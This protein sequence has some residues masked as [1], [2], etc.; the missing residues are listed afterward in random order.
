M[1]LPLLTTTE[2]LSTTTAFIMVR[3]SFVLDWLLPFVF[4][5]TD[6]QIRD[7]VNM[8]FILV[9]VVVVVI[10]D[11]SSLPKDPTKKNI[12]SSQSCRSTNQKNGVARRQA[13]PALF[14]FQHTGIYEWCRR[15][16]SKPKSLRQNV[17]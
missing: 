16:Q 10:I 8:C 11:T 1:V 7:R 9:V 15:I 6:Q 3:L 13:H 5:A 12:L 2:K 4:T 17:Q 14:L